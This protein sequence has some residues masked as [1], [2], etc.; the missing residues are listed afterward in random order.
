MNKLISKTPVQRFKEGRK[1]IKAQEGIRFQRVG[2]TW[3]PGL[4]SATKEYV[5][6]NY[7]TGDYITSKNPEITSLEG[8]INRGKSYSKYGYSWKEGEFAKTPNSTPESTPKSKKGG[9][10]EIS[11]EEKARLKDEKIQK[12]LKRQESQKFTAKPTSEKIINDSVTNPKYWWIKGF[13]NRVQGLGLKSRDDVKAIQKK[14]GVNDDGVWGKDTEEAFINKFKFIPDTSEEIIPMA[15]IQP[16]NIDSNVAP[17]LINTQYIPNFNWR[18]ALNLHYQN[19]FSAKQ[20]GQ[21]PSRNPVER[22][23]NGGIQ[24]FQNAG[25]LPIAPK[26]EDRYK[27]GSKY[28][29]MADGS[30]Y[31]FPNPLYTIADIKGVRTDYPFMSNQGEIKRTIFYAGNS[32]MDTIYTEIPNSVFPVE[33]KMRY[34]NS[35]NKTPEYEILKRR[36]NTAWNLAK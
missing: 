21:F 15:Q 20:G 23:K 6:Y 26:A 35:K 31:L 29:Y 1:I 18:E 25:N 30:L 11:S 17:N 13:R 33:R 7:N 2:S 27:N 16:V 34:A 14:L 10:R 3:F 24:K 4:R 5:F 28:G 8:T 22:F 9:T 36:F 19:P 12:Y 32:P